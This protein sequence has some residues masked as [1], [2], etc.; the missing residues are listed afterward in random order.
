MLQAK[1]AL[2]AVL[3][4]HTSE[5]ATISLSST[6][7][8]TGVQVEAYMMDE[9]SG[10]A[11]GTSWGPTELRPDDSLDIG[12]DLGGSAS[13]G[14]KPYFVHLQQGHALMLLISWA[15]E[16]GDH[17]FGRCSIFWSASDRAGWY[18]P[19]INYSFGR[20]HP[21]EGHALISSALEDPG[22]WAQEI[23]VES[24]PEHRS[25]LPDD[26]ADE[27]TNDSIFIDK[28]T[29]EG[30][31]GFE[32]AASLKLAR[33]DGHT[34]GSGLTVVVGANNSGKSTLWEAFDAT[35]RG[36]RQAAYGESL[37]F[38]M[39]RRNQN[40][41]NGVFVTTS[42]SDGETF[43]IRSLDKNTSE[44][45]AEWSTVQTPQTP[46][47][48]VVPARRS[49]QPSFS[50]RYDSDRGWNL[51]ENHFDRQAVNDDS[52]TGRLF[53]MVKNPEKKETFDQLLAEVAG[54]HVSWNIDMRDGQSYSLQIM[55]QNG[56]NHSSEGMGSGVISL[57]YILD[58]LYDAEPNSVV[59]I[60]E[61][62]LSLHPELVKRLAETLMKHSANKQV[63]IF[64]HSAHLLPWRAVENGATIARVFREHGGSFVGQATETV[65]SQV[66]ALHKDWRNPHVLSAPAVE[67][68][69]LD[70]EVIIVEGQE[71]AVLLPR[72]YDELGIQ[73]R[74]T[75]FGWG[76]GG[77]SGKPT[78]IAKL[79]R[80]LGFKRVVILL[81]NDQQEEVK[82]IRST[83]PSYFVTHIPAADIRD[84][85]C[86]CC[87]AD[88]KY[89]KQGLLSEDGKTLKPELKEA[90]E[91]IL[92]D[93]NKYFS[94][95]TVPEYAD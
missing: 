11:G 79:L 78:T 12:V 42:Y 17:P 44:T 22:P 80:E 29:V 72:I 34:H 88:C 21:N 18:R 15:Y 54:Y 84:K 67:A 45:T 57:L 70:D 76:V 51:S 73:Q 13:N 41:P 77:G 66:A 20:F 63:V 43:T 49:F 59:V 81:D 56:L 30:L 8:I 10:N 60:D 5:K 58:A 16:E 75:I 6:Y 55:S 28:I 23:Q 71:D 87:S 7:S 9:V 95:G 94:D 92:S 37:S 40:T 24:S 4:A 35:A 90:T 36:I 32:T 27:T 50:R 2:E 47:I 83:L 93:V 14:D 86:R 68:L 91:A 3:L 64:T 19:R 26:S 53:H 69:F 46:E 89:T 61:P 62:E 65:A 31:R 38:P 39:G 25:L 52:F 48:V 1:N 85:V 33:P 74:G 82:R